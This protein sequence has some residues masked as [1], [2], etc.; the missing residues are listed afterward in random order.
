[1]Q[2]HLSRKLKETKNLI[3]SVKNDGAVLVE[4][5]EV[6]QLTGFIF[7]P[8]LADGEEK[9]TILAAARRGLPGD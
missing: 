9:A 2:L 8:T 3:A 6:S 7:N 1:M 5:E 4:G